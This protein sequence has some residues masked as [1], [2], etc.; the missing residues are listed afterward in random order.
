LFIL[1]PVNYNWLNALPNKLFEFIQGRLAIAVSPNPLM[2][3][4]V[5]ENQIGIV[6]QD[7]SAEAMATSITSLSI[8]QIMDYKINADLIAKKLNGG[9]TAERIKKSVDT[10]LN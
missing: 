10:L 4:V 9:I 6:A 5:N 2:K 3:Q 8:E 7:Y 1:P